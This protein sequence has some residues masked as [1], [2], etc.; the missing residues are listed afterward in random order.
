MHCYLVYL[1]LFTDNHCYSEVLMNFQLQNFQIM[2]L[3]L[4]PWETVNFGSLKSQ[5]TSGNIENIGIL[6]KQNKPFPSRPIIKCLLFHSKLI[7]AFCKFHVQSVQ[8]C[9]TKIGY[10][11]R[12]QES[13]SVVISIPLA[14]LT[15]VM[16]IFFPHKTSGGTPRRH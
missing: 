13:H 12:Y 14:N 3:R 7:C 6:G 1:R 2:T 11:C 5:S 8:Q 10:T 9:Y 4:V 15:N 16:L